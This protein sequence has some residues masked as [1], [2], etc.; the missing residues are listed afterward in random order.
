MSAYIV[1]LDELNRILD[2]I[3]EGDGIKKAI[4]DACLLVEREAKLK[5]PSK[6]GELRSSIAA[7]A[8]DFEGQVGTPL[9]YGV[10]VEYGTG[11]FAAKGNGRKEVPWHYQDAKGQWHST[12]GQ[13]PQPF[14][15]PAFNENRKEIIEMIKEGLLDD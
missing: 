13:P 7:E 10:Y 9:Q 1:G 8:H 4:N 14:L 11:L 5:C 6:T 15:I 3:A 2:K 12:S